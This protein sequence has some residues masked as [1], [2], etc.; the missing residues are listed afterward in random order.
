V[1]IFRL[2]VAHNSTT[3]YR[4]SNLQVDTS[5]FVTEQVF[6]PSRDGTRVPMFIT[7][8]R[9]ALRDAQQPTLLYGY[10]G[11]NSSATPSFR[12]QVLVW[13]QMGGMFAEANIRGGGEYG[14]AWHAAGTG[15]HKQNVFDDFIAAA[16]SR[17]RC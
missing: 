6:Y 8:R 9:D 3:L 17:A 15:I 7:R 2:D 5:S 12:A 14:E 1:Q 11:F 4:H 10:G 16:C 13:L